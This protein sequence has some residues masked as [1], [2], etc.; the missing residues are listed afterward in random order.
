MYID[1]EYAMFT[2]KRDKGGLIY[3][4][5]MYKVLIAADQ[6]FRTILSSGK[7]HVKSMYRNLLID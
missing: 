4:Q 3:S 5:D 7:G 6:A 2:R 1:S